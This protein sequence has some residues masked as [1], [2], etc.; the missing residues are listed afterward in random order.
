MDILINRHEAL[1]TTFSIRNAVPIQVITAEVAVPIQLLNMDG[2]DSDAIRHKVGELAGRPFAL[3]K[4]PLVRVHVLRLAEDEHHLLLLT[5]HI[6][7]DAWSSGIMF[8]DLAAA[9]DALAAGERPTL[10]AL[11]VQYADYGPS[12]NVNGLMDRSSI[13][14]STIG[15]SNS[16]A[17]PALL[18][19]PT[20]RARPRRQTYNG[21]RVSIVL[22][23][24]LTAALKALARQ[25]NG[26]LFMVLL[27][28]FDVLLARYSGQD[29]VL[30]GSPIAGRRRTELEDL[31]GLF[32]NTLVFRTD[33]TG[34]PSYREL[35]ARVRTT[36]LEAY[37]HQELPFEKLVETLQPVRDQSRSPLFQVMLIHQN[38]P[39]EARPVRNLEVAPGEI[40]RG[41]NRKI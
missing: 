25:E 40:A 35:L 10:P 8:R 31:V 32:V 18:D 29:D 33:L 5:H 4:G 36:A 11:S 12:G 19:L 37:A 34:N 3:D 13:A 28:G 6:V 30:V 41:R 9:Y 14:R 1:R 38:A 22:P 15:R 20:D 27:A 7:S 21:G 17:H 23:A 2:A 24:S 39:W 26:T 16:R